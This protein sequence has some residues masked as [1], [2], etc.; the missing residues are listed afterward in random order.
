MEILQVIYHYHVIDTPYTMSLQVPT[1]KTFGKTYF[2][3]SS[4]IAW[5]E[6]S[7]HVQPSM[8]KSQL[9]KY[10]QNFVFSNLIANRLICLYIIKYFSYFYLFYSKFITFVGFVLRTSTEISV[11]TFCFIFIF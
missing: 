2:S 6:L 8:T 7:S 10:S 3:H 11:F 1:V 4:T 9:T 5:N